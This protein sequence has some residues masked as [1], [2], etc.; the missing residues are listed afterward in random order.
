MHP[1]FIAV[2]ISVGTTFGLL[3]AILAQSNSRTK[4][5]GATIW[6]S[7]AFAAFI[8][9]LLTGQLCMMPDDVI[10]HAETFQ[11]FA[12]GG[13]IFSLSTLFV[14]FTMR[15]ASKFAVNEV[16]Q[17]QRSAL[18]GLANFDKLCE[19]D[20]EI[21]VESLS[22]A[23]RKVEMDDETRKC[24]SYLRD[25]IDDAGHKVADERS[26]AVRVDSKVDASEQ[27]TPVFAVN[28]ADLEKWSS[29][30]A[31]RRQSWLPRNS[32]PL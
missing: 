2:S 4:S 27:L 13:I 6:L 32:L 3:N 21:T 29:R 18:V 1:V 11:L 23:L 8:S 5:R 10:G 28:R 24:V 16:Q 26:F 31:D 17:A 12:F 7:L 9:I 15:D 25:N 30:V 14:P 22:Q 19:A 20:G